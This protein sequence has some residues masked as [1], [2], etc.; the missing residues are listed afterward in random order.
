MKTSVET[1]CFA[2]LWMVQMA[3]SWY[4]PAPLV[5]FWQGQL[6]IEDQNT[7]STIAFF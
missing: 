7:S 4:Q 6:I 3:S 1:I 2:F 5:G